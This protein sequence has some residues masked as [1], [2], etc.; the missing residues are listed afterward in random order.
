MKR[1][2]NVGIELRRGALR[3]KTS[4][5]GIHKFRYNLFDFNAGCPRRFTMSMPETKVLYSVDEY[6]AIERE[7]E[8]RH[9]FLDGEI[10]EMAGESPAHGAICT[11]LTRIVSTD[12]LGSPC[13]AFSKDTKVRSGP[14]LQ[15]RRTTKGLFSYPD[16]VVV[17]GEMQFHDEH[18]DVLLNPTVIIEVLSPATHAFDRGKKWLRYQT[19][20]PTLSDYLMVAQSRPQ[21][22][23]Y[24]RQ[25]NGQWLYS[26]IKGL[27]GI[28]RIPSVGVTLK[29]ADVYDRVVFPPD[30][31]LDD[32][33]PW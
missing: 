12:L 14:L 17:C 20:I 8:E 7:S 23:H 18:Q 26:R 16:L 27:E 13:Q 24:Q 6:L 3:S 30:E 29:L 22:E 28:V 9:E 10:Y 15:S 19:W 31:E 21:I 11:N 2:R 33:D 4:L 1:C 32:E 25:A 5:T